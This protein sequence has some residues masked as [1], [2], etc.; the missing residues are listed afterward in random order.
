MTVLRGH[1]SM[2]LEGSVPFP[3]ELMPALRTCYG[4]VL[5]LNNLINQ[6]ILAMR[7]RDGALVP[8]W[9]SVDF[10]AWLRGVAHDVSIVVASTGHGFQLELPRTRVKGRADVFLLA[11]ALFNLVDNA[12]KF[13]PRNSIIRVACRRSGDAVEIEVIDKGTGFPPDFKLQPFARV[14]R[15]LGFERPGVGVGLFIAEGVAS[16]HGGSLDFRSSGSGSLVR[17]TLPVSKEEAA[18]KP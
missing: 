6:M 14:D 8:S 11:T 9:R 13:S 17:I 10:S 7:I 3:A 12:Q 16:A 2:W 15:E 1:L 18:S 4:S 5:Q